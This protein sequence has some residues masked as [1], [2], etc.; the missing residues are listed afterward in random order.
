MISNIDRHCLT[1]VQTMLA[2]R[3][4]RTRN[5]RADAWPSAGCS[6]K[7]DSRMRST[8]APHSSLAALCAYSTGHTSDRTAIV[9]LCAALAVDAGDAIVPADPKAPCGAALRVSPHPAAAASAAD[10]SR[11]EKKLFHPPLRGCLQS[12]VKG[13]RR[14]R[15]DPVDFPGRRRQ[16]GTQVPRSRRQR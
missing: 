13:W 1:I 16:N 15:Q 12:V 3:V 10:P 14:E 4:V 2:S 6:S 9:G 8:E 5:A 11:H 7:R